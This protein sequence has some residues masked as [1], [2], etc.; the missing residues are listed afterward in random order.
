[1]SRRS[2]RHVCATSR[3]D[4][5]LARMHSSPTSCPPRSACIS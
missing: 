2:R 5:P 1:M 3:H 4:A